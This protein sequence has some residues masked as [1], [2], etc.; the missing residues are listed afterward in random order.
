MNADSNLPPYKLV[1]ILAMWII[2]KM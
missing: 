2:Y 1:M